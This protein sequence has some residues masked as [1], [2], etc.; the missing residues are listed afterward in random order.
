[1]DISQNTS[2]AARFNISITPTLLLIEKGQEDYMSVAAGVITLTE[3]ER[4]LYRAIRY[5][6]GSTRNDNFSDCIRN[7][8]A[9]PTLPAGQPGSVGVSILHGHPHMRLVAADA[10]EAVRPLSIRLPVWHSRVADQLQATK[11]FRTDN[12]RHPRKEAICR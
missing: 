6:Q 5:L 12:G 4:K 8:S 10:T 9:P 2:A 1:M 11:T 7:S 3:L